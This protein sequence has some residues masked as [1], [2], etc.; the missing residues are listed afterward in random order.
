MHRNAS[1]AL[2]RLRELDITPLREL[3]VLAPGLGIVSKYA[4][5][6]LQYSIDFLRFD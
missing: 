6:A 2:H 5:A 3:G 1:L 4:V